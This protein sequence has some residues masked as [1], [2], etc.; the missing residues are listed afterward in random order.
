[1]DTLYVN[2]NMCFICFSPIRE[3]APHDFKSIDCEDQSY[4]ECGCCQDRSVH[5]EC[6]EEWT[7]THCSICK[8]E[9]LLSLHLKS[10]KDKRSIWNCIPQ[11]LTRILNV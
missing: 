4:Y 6:G 3:N 11:I 9:V 7:D 1:M 10:I 8:Q 5:L 2:S